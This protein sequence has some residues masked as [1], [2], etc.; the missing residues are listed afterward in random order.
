MLLHFIVLVACFFLSGKKDPKQALQDRLLEVMEHLDS[1]Q[2]L[3]NLDCF[4]ALGFSKSKSTFKVRRFQRLSSNPQ[5]S[6]FLLKKYQESDEE[7]NSLLN[8]NIELLENQYKRIRTES[9]QPDVLMFK[10]GD[11]K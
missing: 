6:A 9:R 3:I 1:M 10:I 2:S 4:V 7:E 11:W 5:R 8:L